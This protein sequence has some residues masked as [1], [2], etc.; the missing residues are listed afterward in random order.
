MLCC[1]ACDGM[2][3]GVGGDI[4]TAY[5]DGTVSIGIGNT[6]PFAPGLPG[7]SP[8]P[9]YRPQPG[10]NAPGWGRPGW[11]GSPYWHHA[12]WHPGPGPGPGPYLPY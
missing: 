8:W 4:S 2:Y 7:Y 9:G 5:P 1:T 12:P 10:W 11:G 6:V 3:V